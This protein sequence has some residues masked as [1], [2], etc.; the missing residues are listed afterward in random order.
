MLNKSCWQLWVPIIYVDQLPRRC[1]IIY[2]AMWGSDI[3]ILCLVL[4]HT[5]DAV[6]PLAAT[7]A[8]RDHRW[9]HVPAVLRHVGLYTDS[10]RVL[11][12][13]LRV[14]LL[15]LAGPTYASSQTKGINLS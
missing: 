10:L 6:L 13:L 8:N 7:A 14:L 9:R 2:I 15:Q 3:S 11:P 1:A 5:L 4:V 12:P